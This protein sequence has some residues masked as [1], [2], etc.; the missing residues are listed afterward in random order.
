MIWEDRKEL[1]QKNPQNQIM[2]FYLRL[3]LFVLQDNQINLPLIQLFQ[4]GYLQ[5]YIHVFQIHPGRHFKERQHENKL[6]STF[7]YTVNS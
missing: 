2:R 4:K 6:L 5:D 1:R 3:D 7:N